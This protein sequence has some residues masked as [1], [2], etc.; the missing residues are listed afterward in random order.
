M[1]LHGIICIPRSILRR[2]KN[3]EG[4]TVMGRDN[5]KGA[6][7]ST[8]S[9]PQTP[10]NQKIKPGDMKEEMSRELGELTKLTPKK[11]RFN[12]KKRKK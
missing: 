11:E 9:L 2:N 1:L 3:V 6:S 4:G 8:N 10:K 5:H 7:N 12:T